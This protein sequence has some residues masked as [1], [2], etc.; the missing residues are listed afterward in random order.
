MYTFSLICATLN[1][2]KELET[3][4]ESLAAQT[5]KR[6]ELIIVDQNKDDR[7]DAVY[8]KLCWHGY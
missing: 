4:L 1:R 6:F 3:L 5:Y 7:L 2:E 8:Q